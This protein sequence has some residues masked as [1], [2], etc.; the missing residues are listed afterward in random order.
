MP[1]QNRVDPWGKL[2]AVNARGSFLGNRGILH[3]DQKNY[4]SLEA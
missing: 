3:N 1:L 2:I 4:L